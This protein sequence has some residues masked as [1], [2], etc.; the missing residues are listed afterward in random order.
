MSADTPTHEYKETST[1]IYS[2][3]E[4]ASQTVA[5]NDNGVDNSNRAAADNDQAQNGRP[6]NGHLQS[7]DSSQQQILPRDSV[8]FPLNDQALGTLEYD[9]WGAHLE[10]VLKAI[11]D[12]DDLIE[13]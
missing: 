1:R 12:S 7:V 3:Q 8:L 2:T 9:G 10:E 5:G 4:T 11:Q 13:F 6:D